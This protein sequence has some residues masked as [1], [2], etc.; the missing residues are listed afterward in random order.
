MPIAII[1][2]P[3]SSIAKLLAKAPMIVPAINIVT[4]NLKSSLVDIV[5]IKKGES[6]IA[7]AKSSRNPEVSHWT[8]TADTL[9]SSIKWGDTIAK[10]VSEKIPIKVRTASDITVTIS[11]AEN[12]LLIFS[13][14]YYIMQIK[15]IWLK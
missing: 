8:A 7:A 1:S 2:L 3:A 10:L 6:G 13:P 4:A 9:N 15:K 11:L 12:K 14:A 5:F